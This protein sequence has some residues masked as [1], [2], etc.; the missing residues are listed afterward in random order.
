MEQ[1]DFTLLSSD[2]STTRQVTCFAP[3][4]RARAL[5]IVLHDAGQNAAHY[6]SLASF[7]TGQGIAL[8]CPFFAE[9]GLLSAQEKRPN[10]ARSARPDRIIQEDLF[11]IQT[12]AKK[13][14]PDT[15]LFLMGTGT[16]SHLVLSCLTT[17]G[18]GLHGVVLA[19][20]GFFSPAATSLKL[21]AISALSSIR[22]DAY[23]RG[24]LPQKV[25]LLAVSS[26]C[27]EM[28][29]A[30]LPK[31]L[32][33]FLA[34]GADD[35]YGDFGAG[36]RR[37]QEKL[38]TSGIADVSCTFY[39]RTGHDLFQEKT[40]ET[41]YGDLEAFFAARTGQ[42]RVSSYD[43]NKAYDEKKAQEQQEYEIEQIL[44]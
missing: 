44:L 22:S 41:F 13:R 7:L 43:S 6:G 24:I 10:S 18:D 16:G 28:Q 32:S 30:K 23:R 34:S 33:F 17:H 12:E 20:T 15:P 35:P 39:P 9:Y 4:D 1:T 21:Y 5:L 14:F 38:L 19:G 37:I 29:I 8:M 27:S 42:D 2:A 3:E 11:L 31:N 26:S 36:V 40:A 25:R